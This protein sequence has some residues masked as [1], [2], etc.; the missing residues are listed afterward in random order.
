M[1]VVGLPYDIWSGVLC[2]YCVRVS[3]EE[4]PFRSS[5]AMNAEMVKSAWKHP[6]PRGREIDAARWTVVHRKGLQAQFPDPL[7]LLCHPHGA[8]VTCPVYANNGYDT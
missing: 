8:L 6:P 1:G 7:Q 5:G 2:I 4:R 3:I